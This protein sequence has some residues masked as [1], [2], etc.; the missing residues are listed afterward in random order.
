MG[1][2]QKNGYETIFPFQEAAAA[3]AKLVKADILPPTME[4]PFQGIVAQLDQAQKRALGAE[5]ELIQ[6]GGLMKANDTAVLSANGREIPG[7]VDRFLRH[8]VEQLVET[9]DLLR[10]Q[11]TQD[12]TPCLRAP[13][14]EFTP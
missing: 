11:C 12:D 6:V 14:P 9:E 1:V 5:T 13:Y 2:K 3:A 7:P 10:G 8:F 4:G